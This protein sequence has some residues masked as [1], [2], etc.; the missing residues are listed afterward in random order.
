MGTIASKHLPP[1]VLA[2]AGLRRAGARG[3]RAGVAL[4]PP[5]AGHV[6]LE[7]PVEPPTVTHHAKRI[8][9]RQG[10][11]R[12]VDS[13]ELLAARRLYEL[14]IPHRPGPLVAPIRGPAVLRITFTWRARDGDPPQWHAARPDLSNSVKLLEDVLVERGYL[15]DDCH[16][17]LSVMAKRLG[18]VP[19]VRVYARTLLTG[20]DVGQEY[21]FGGRE[22][23]G[24]VWPLGDQVANE[25]DRSRILQAAAAAGERPWPGFP[26]RAAAQN[27]PTA[28]PP[29]RRATKRGATKHPQR[30]GGNRA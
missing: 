6:L 22:H 23:R 10:R 3:G 11:P 14:A 28:K 2:A 4:G 26:P 19:A 27:E 12:L 1:E 30:T 29:R 7:L 16:V 25:I 24:V 21:P 13:D 8:V 17:A 18:P 9:T 5:L 20:T 15:A